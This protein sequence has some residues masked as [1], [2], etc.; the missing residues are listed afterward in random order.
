MKVADYKDPEEIIDVSFDFTDDLAGEA[1][2]AAS[3]VV[4][5]A[6]SSGADPNVAAMISGAPTING[7]VVLQRI[8][9]GVDKAAYHLRCRID[10][11]SG[12]KLVLA[13]QLPVKAV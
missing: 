2:V 1:I 10:T 9:N 11:A 3:A 13:L 6:V 7:S 8:V 4:S 5:I 12:R